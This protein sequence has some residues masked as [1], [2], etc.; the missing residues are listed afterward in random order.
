M[1]YFAYNYVL[2][3]SYSKEPVMSLKAHIKDMLS[4]TSSDT[5]LLSIRL[6]SSIVNQIDELASE[7]DRTR[8]ELV[9]VFINGGIDELT[10]QLEQSENNTLVE[11]SEK[12]DSERYFLLN[13]NYNNSELDH[14]KMLENGEA[15]A[16]YKG[17][18]ENIEYLTENDHV[19]LYQSANGICGY[20]L[21]DK[22]LVI[23]E[24]QGHKDECYTRKLNN[25]KSNFKPI[26][27][28]TCKDITKSNMGFR[29]T[30]VSL[31]KEQGEAIIAE[32]EKRMK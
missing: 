12:T 22:K 23:T 30:M 17:W 1:F 10:K 21:A 7:V 28:K 13:T 27:A 19:F 14:Y 31:S 16:F 25:F 5:Q 24:H 29:K 26:T 18:K 4:N 11:N 9:T 15:S 20:G 6:A 3:F 2:H 32:I 8:S